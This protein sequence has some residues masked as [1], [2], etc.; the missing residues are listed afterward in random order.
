MAFL[1]ESECG[2]ELA[3]CQR[4]G[5][6]RMLLDQ[7]GKGAPCGKLL[8]LY[9]TSVKE[10]NKGLPS[11]RRNKDR[12]ERRILQYFSVSSPQGTEW[13]FFSP[14]LESEIGRN[15]SAVEAI[16]TQKPYPAKAYKQLMTMQY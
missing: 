4:C 5:F 2:V 13:D 14:G 7:F 1:G 3:R 10:M 8:N 15:K 6:V 11:I 12:G 9:R 16:V